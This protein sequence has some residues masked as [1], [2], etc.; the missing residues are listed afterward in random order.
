MT[1]HRH[2]KLNAAESQSLP[3]ELWRPCPTCAYSKLCVNHCTIF[4][5]LHDCITLHNLHLAARSLW[6]LQGSR[7]SVP[8]L[9]WF[10]AARFSCRESPS[11]LGHIATKC[12]DI[13]G[14][15]LRWMELI[16]FLTGSSSHVEYP[17]CIDT[18]HL[19]I[20]IYM[21]CHTYNAF[22]NQYNLCMCVRIYIYIHVCM[23]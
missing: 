19:Y 22:V 3:G 23:L 14:K 18:M 6:W 4:A 13:D 12:Y 20:Y 8:E 17:D 5:H 10:R 9:D 11:N 2:G 21:C 16:Y 7:G 1:W 15:S